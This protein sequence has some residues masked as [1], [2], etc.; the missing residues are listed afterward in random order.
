MSVAPKNEDGREDAS[1]RMYW[2]A[3]H[4]TRAANEKVRS[5]ERYERMEAAVHA[6]AAVELMAKAILAK[7]D[8]RFLV[9]EQ[10]GH[11][12]LLDALID[13]G[14]LSGQPRHQKL[15][16]TLSAAR[17]VEVVT[18]IR[19]ELRPHRQAADGALRAR[20]AAAHAA[21]VEEDKLA[22]CVTGGSDFVLAGVDCFGR[23]RDEF[24]GQRLAQV[25]QMEVK[26]RSAALR[27]AARQKVETARRTY[28]RFVAQL[29]DDGASVLAQFGMREPPHGDHTE[30][31]DCPACANR[32]W[33]TWNVEVE[34]EYEGPDDYS[35]SAYLDFIGFDCYY[36]GLRLSDH[37]CEILGIDPNGDPEVDFGDDRI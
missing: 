10:E 26:E 22:D 6:G 33:L 21:V 18:R 37:E 19:E 8:W 27:D 7:V 36:C 35:T 34:V 5:L 11:H 9:H 20:N 29:P 31:F 15:R 28:D 14:K 3:S 32:G 4:H 30:P 25:V 12:V 2:A 1:E 17:A 23:S 13:Q 24:L 16:T